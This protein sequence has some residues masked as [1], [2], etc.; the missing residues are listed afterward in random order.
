MA[1]RAFQ[2]HGEHVHPGWLLAR[3]APE[4]VKGDTRMAG[5]GGDGW[6]TVAEVIE[7]GAVP[8]VQV[9]ADGRTLVLDRLPAGAGEG[10]L[11]LVEESGSGRSAAVGPALARAGSGRSDMLRLAVEHGLELS[12]PPSAR[13][14]AETAAPDADDPALDDLERLPFITVDPAGARDLDQAL[15]LGRRPGGGFVVRY[16]LADAAHFVAPGSA[17]FAHALASGASFY[18]PGLRVPMLPPRLSEDL[19]SLVPGRAR[20]AL[21]VECRLGAGGEVESTRFVRARVRSRARLSYRGAQRFFDDPWG[22]ARRHREWLESLELLAEVGGARLAEAQR[23]QVARIHREEI[24]LQPDEAQPGGFR[25]SARARLPVEEWNEQLSLLVNVEGARLL[26]A[27]LGQ[28]RV[29]PVFRVHPGPSPEDLEQL[30]RR[31]AVLASRRGLD[32]GRWAWDPDGS[33]L[34]SFLARLPRAGRAARLAR[35]IDRQAI[36][37]QQPSRYAPEPAPHSGIGAPH[38]ARLSSPMREVVGVFTH[39][40]VLE[41]LGAVP[42]G[43]TQDDLALRERVVEAGNRSRELQRRLDKA[44]ARVVLDRWL[45]VRGE[46][47][48]VST[49]MGFG[50]DRLYVQLDLPRLDLKVYLGDQPG[51]WRVDP[52]EIEA[53]GEGQVV[54]LG[55]VVRLAVAGLDRSRDRWRLVVLPAEGSLPATRQA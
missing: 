8:R 44:A 50:H 1:S 16:A 39:K 54:R 26:A 20:R 33:D 24:E 18:L 5:M 19:V 2:A 53:R 51:R 49:V 32:P 14:E 37:I 36:R 31:L 6:R 46:G 55:D 29:Q 10:D 47:A 40:E 17:L 45:S 12:H 9:L 11:V 28:E 43:R 34:G 38:Y 25:A 15:H 21:V 7:G 22:G 48:L 3:G 30:A 4:L 41:L 52:L 27:G 42:C 23:R 13:A 35:A